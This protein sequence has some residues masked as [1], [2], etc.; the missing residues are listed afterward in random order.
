MWECRAREMKGD[1]H[2]KKLHLKYRSNG[3]IVQL[4]CTYRK[5]VGRSIAQNVSLLAAKLNDKLAE[6]L[7][8]EQCPLSI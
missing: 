2:H 5:S 6:S 1:A 8:L 3:S 4:L 7:T